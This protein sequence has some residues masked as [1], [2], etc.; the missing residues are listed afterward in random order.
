MEAVADYDDNNNMADQ[1]S[2]PSVIPNIS[3]SNLDKISNSNLNLNPPRPHN[4]AEK[5]SKNKTLSCQVI[6]PPHSFVKAKVEG[7]TGNAKRRNSKSPDSNRQIKSYRVTVCAFN[8]HN[9]SNTEAEEKD[10]NTDDMKGKEHKEEDGFED[11]FSFSV[12]LP[13]AGR[14]AAR[15]SSHH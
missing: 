9:K 2:S 10:T 3:N 15:A 8:R 12:V 5:I 13:D 4:N 1:P 14:K 11:L 7:R 6:F